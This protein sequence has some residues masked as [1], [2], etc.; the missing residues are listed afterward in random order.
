MFKLTIK[1]KLDKNHCKKKKSNFIYTNFEEVI[2]QV[3]GAV[4]LPVLSVS[5]NFKN[6]DCLINDT[7]FDKVS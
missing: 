5:Y 6:P 2:P 3:I 1:G 4:C 7:N